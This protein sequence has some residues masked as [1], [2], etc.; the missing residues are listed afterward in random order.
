MLVFDALL[1]TGKPDLTQYGLIPIR[2]IGTSHLFPSGTD[3]LLVPTDDQVR[4]ALTG[5]QDLLALNAEHW[6]DTA[7]YVDLLKKAHRLFPHLRIGYYDVV[8]KRDYWRAIRG[9]GD[10]KYIEWQRVNDSLRPIAMQADVMF[11]S[12][13]T[14]YADQGGWVKYA[15]ANVSEAERYNKSVYTFIWPYYHDSNTA[16]KGQLIPADYWRLQL[17]T[18]KSLEVDGIVIWG[19]Y[20][21]PWDPAAPWWLETL[22]FINAN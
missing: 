15:I 8:P 9:E 5:R 10:P 14:F 13:Y 18:L 2:L 20:K 19:G 11:P 7:S 12:L 1:F 17:E 4:M 16:L 3:K 6:Q 21:L 22:N